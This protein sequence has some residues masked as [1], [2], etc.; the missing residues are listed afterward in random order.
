[1]CRKQKYV[2]RYEPRLFCVPLRASFGH[3]AGPWNAQLAPEDRF[4]IEAC[5]A[6]LI[7]L[8]ESS[9][10]AAFADIRG[11]YFVGPTTQVHGGARTNADDSTSY[12]A[13]SGQGRFRMSPSTPEK[14]PRP[15]RLFFQGETVHLDGF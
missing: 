8:A 6:R 9:W 12:R 4:R 5:A 10:N 7:R 15:S 3:F 14:S 13:E 11:K 1:V 2:K